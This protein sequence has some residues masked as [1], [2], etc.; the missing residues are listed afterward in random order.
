[1]DALSSS[2]GLQ[3]KKIDI[4]FL[5]PFAA[6]IA[7]R[8]FLRT[9]DVGS[10]LSAC[11]SQSK[12][13]ERQILADQRI[14]L[15]LLDYTCTSV[16]VRSKSQRDC[17]EGRCHPYGVGGRIPPSLAYPN[18]ASSIPSQSYQVHL[19]SS[20]GIPVRTIAPLQGRSDYL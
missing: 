1:M 13:R 17:T 5:F 7:R 11:S 15:E 12:R 2:G 20:A 18:I 16:R 10:G 8:C 6:R 14:A 19:P 3:L 4:R 9:F